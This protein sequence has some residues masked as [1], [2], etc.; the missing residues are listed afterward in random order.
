MLPEPHAI[1]GAE[2]RGAGAAH[3][4]VA[5]YGNC[6]GEMKKQAYVAAAGAEPAEPAFEAAAAAAGGSGLLG[7]H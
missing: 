7:W 3:A 6:L 1:A 5:G 4:P 2:G